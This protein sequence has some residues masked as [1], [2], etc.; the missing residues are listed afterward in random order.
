MD[1]PSPK[2]T[3]TQIKAAQQPLYYCF[4]P[5]NYEVQ[6]QYNKPRHINIS[7]TAV[8]ILEHTDVGIFPVINVTHTIH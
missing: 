5:K 8:A 4:L 6:T 3:A 7:T 2:G 1:K